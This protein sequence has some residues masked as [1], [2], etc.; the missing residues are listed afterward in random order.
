M[1]SVQRSMKLEMTNMTMIDIATGLGGALA[2][3]ASEYLDHVI[4]IRDSY[5]FGECEIL[6]C[7]NSRLG[8][9]IKQ[10]KHAVMSSFAIVKT[11]KIHEAGCNRPIYG[12]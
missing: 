2:T 10:K 6:D 12:Q 5:F 4:E 1:A 3:G 9:C 7:D 11:K 8:Y